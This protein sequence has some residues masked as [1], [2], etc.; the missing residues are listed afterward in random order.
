MKDKIK[1][2]EY[3][4]LSKRTLSNLDSVLEDNIHM[5]LGLTTETAEIADVFKKKLAYKKEIDWVNIQEELGDVM[6]Y[7]VNMCNINNWDL[8]DIL[9][10][11]INKLKVRFPD[12]FTEENAL[13]RD[14]TSE[15]KELEK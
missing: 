14:L 4:N 7:I 8:R 15:R 10:N 12:K 11:N 5:S 6:F 9:Q 2:E 13:N 1:I 3:Q